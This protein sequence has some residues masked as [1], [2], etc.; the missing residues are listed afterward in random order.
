[1][2]KGDKIWTFSMNIGYI[3]IYKGTITDPSPETSRRIL[4][5]YD[6]MFFD[7]DHT[8]TLAGKELNVS[9]HHIYPSYEILIEALRH[10]KKE[11]IS[12]ILE[13]LKVAK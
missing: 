8:F 11:V 13:S 4:I 1:M 2:K 6:K 9:K 10:H 12:S 3:T 7:N 5:H